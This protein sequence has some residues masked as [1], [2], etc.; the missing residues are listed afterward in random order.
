MMNM[1]WMAA[2]VLFLTGAAHAADDR[3]MPTQSTVDRVSNEMQFPKDSAIEDESKRLR[4]RVNKA[5]EKADAIK[6]GGIKI[7]VPPSPV[8]TPEYMAKRPDLDLSKM[9]EY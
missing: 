5:I 6:K 8:N 4:P 1:L 9:A 2:S 7:D 3:R